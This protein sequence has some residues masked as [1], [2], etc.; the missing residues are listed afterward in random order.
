MVM[1]ERSNPEKPFSRLLPASSRYWFLSPSSTFSQSQITYLHSPQEESTLLIP[2]T[3][4]LPVGILFL[5]SVAPLTAPSQNTTTTTTT[6][7][8]ILIPNNT[9]PILEIHAYL[10]P[11][12]SC[13]GHPTETDEMRPETFTY[14][15]SK[16]ASNSPDGHNQHPLHTNIHTDEYPYAQIPYSQMWAET[17][18]WLP[19]VFSNL[20]P[21]TGKE[22]DGVYTS[23]FLHHALFTGGISPNTGKWDPW[24][25]MH[26]SSLEILKG[27]GVDFLK[28]EETRSNWIDEKRRERWWIN[29]DAVN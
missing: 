5:E 11:L 29:A 1:V 2:P 24:E 10:A 6:P 21:N 13:Q 12:P 3:S 19:E 15:L 18:A 9:L 8:P 22:I 7:M 27:T 26:A 28:D 17:T 20:P 14:L 16:V 25:T 23:F 4:L